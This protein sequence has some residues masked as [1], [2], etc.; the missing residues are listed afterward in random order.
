MNGIKILDDF[1]LQG[2]TSGKK[3][4]SGSL[5]QSGSQVYFTDCSGMQVYSY[6]VL[7]NTL[8]F[9]PSMIILVARP[10]SYS[11]PA[12]FYSTVYCANGLD[13]TN[14]ATI[15]TVRGTSTFKFYK[16]G[17]N[18]F[19]NTTGFRLPIEIGAVSIEWYAFE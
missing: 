19:V 17:D 7:V 2:K 9:K 4:A 14:T 18:G 12:N 8:D 6:P 1:K 5:T 15:Y 3:S 16:L 10:S 13:G 11:S